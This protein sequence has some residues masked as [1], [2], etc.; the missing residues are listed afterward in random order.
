MA[1]WAS[2]ET[3]RS[4]PVSRLPGWTRG[5]SFCK[6]VA[7]VGTSRVIPRFRHYA[8]GLDVERSVCALHAVDSSG[9]VLG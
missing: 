4:E 8:P 5:L 9:R 3:A 2:L 7:F 6:D 1:S